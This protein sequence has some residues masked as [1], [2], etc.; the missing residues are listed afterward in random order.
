MRI[1]YVSQGVTPH[2]IR[3][4]TALSNSAH[5]VF[6]LPLTQISDEVVLPKRVHFL[7][8]GDRTLREIIA[9]VSPDR[10]HAGPLHS[11]AYAVTNASDVPLIA[12]SWGYDLLREID[13]D[14][15]ALQCV[16]AVLNKAAYLLCDCRASFQ[17]A[18]ALGYPEQQIVTFP[19]GVDVTHFSPDAV[20]T[21]REE[22]GWQSAFVILCTRSW[23]PI[24]GVERI[25]QAFVR[26]AQQFD[27]VRLLLVGGGSQEEL[28]RHVLSAPQVMGKVYF[29]GKCNQQNLP[30]YYR[31]ADV[32]VS[33]SVVDGTSI[34]LLEAMAC[35]L[36]VLVSDIPGNRE[37]VENNVHGWLF[38]SEDIDDLVA[39][40]VHAKQHHQERRAMS[41]QV[42][43]AVLDRA[44][45]D[46]HAQTL[47]LL[48]EKAVT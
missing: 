18:V 15:Q 2:D 9:D 14:P 12:V 41:K 24:Y 29:A 44:N 7:Q 13:K 5:T 36:P 31:A 21:L 16:K 30:A 17:K 20:S 10:I 35:G 45:W 3:F 46:Q 6:F 47:R 43:H 11:T 26:L 27:D 1:L 37:W 34:S 32:Y 8:C 48:Y 39:K 19:W 40:L 25:A 38:G 4:L 42:R 33:A 22:L 23:E 28:I